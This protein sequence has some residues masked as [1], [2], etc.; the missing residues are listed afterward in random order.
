VATWPGNSVPGS[1]TLPSNAQTRTW[2]VAV[3]Q[4]LNVDTRGD[5]FTV[6]SGGGGGGSTNWI[7]LN[8]AHPTPLHVGQEVTLSARYNYVGDRQI[9]IRYRVAMGSTTEDLIVSTPKYGTTRRYTPST[10]GT[11]TV[12]AYLEEKRWDPL[13]GYYWAPVATDTGSF[14]ADPKMATEFVLESAR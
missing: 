10:A 12:Y 11:Y 9:R 13:N 8:I 7:K 3:D 6:T 1:Y 14:T 4:I 5:T 2:R